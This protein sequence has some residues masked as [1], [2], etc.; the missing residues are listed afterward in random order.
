MS[1]RGAEHFCSV[2]CLEGAS[3]S[4]RE[5]PWGNEGGVWVAHHSIYY[6]RPSPFSSPGLSFLIG[7]VDMV[8]VP[9]SGSLRIMCSYC[10]QGT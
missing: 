2:Q 6:T 4:G 7:K 9:P 5:Q 8:T 1:L 10:V 3:A